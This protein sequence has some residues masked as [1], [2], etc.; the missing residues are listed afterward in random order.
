MEKA[1]LRC[2]LVTGASRRIGR[3]IAEALVGRGFAVALHASERS[4]P[5][6][7]AFCAELVQKGARAY[8]LSGDL[9]RTE[10]VAR[11]VAAARGHGSDDCGGWWPASCL[12]D[13]GC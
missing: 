4:R 10:D 11:L 13:A 1:D 8:V 3:A 5:E 2:A 7:E 6:A 12:E 9:A